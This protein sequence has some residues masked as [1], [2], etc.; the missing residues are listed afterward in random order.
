[1]GATVCEA[2]LRAADLEL[3][4]VVDPAGALD[5]PAGAGGSATSAYPC[6]PV[7]ASLDVVASSGSQVAVDFTRREAAMANMAWCSEHGVHAVVGTTGFDEADLAQLERWFDPARGTGCVVAPNFAIGAVLMMHFSELAAP[8]FDAAEVVELH[9]DAKVDS[10]SG[11]AVL[12]AQR[13]AASG[14]DLSGPRPGQP[15]QERLAGARGAVGPG[16]V[17]IHSVRMPGL[18][19]HHEVLLGAAGQTLTLR[20]DSYDRSSFMP[21]VLAAVRAVPGIAG[22]TVGLDTILGLGRH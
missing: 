14:A 12:T 5:R 22:L 3:V 1:M 21:G 4:A 19:A 8:W 10:P 18:V 20:H 11:T 7:S 2:V 6:G 9:H 13:M 16:G 17:R 15:E